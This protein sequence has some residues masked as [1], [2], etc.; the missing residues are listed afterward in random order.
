[1]TSLEMKMEEME[2]QKEKI[3]L[4]RDKVYKQSLEAIAPHMPIMISAA[5]KLAASNAD[6]LKEQASKAAEVMKHSSEVMDK[7]VSWNAAKPP[8]SQKPSASTFVAKNAPFL[9]PN[10]AAEIINHDQDLAPGKPTTPKATGPGLPRA[11]LAADRLRGSLGPCLLAQQQPNESQDISCSW[12]MM[13]T[14]IPQDAFIH[15]GCAQSGRTV[16]RASTYQLGNFLTPLGYREGLTREV[17]F[18]GSAVANGAAPSA[19]HAG[20]TQE[21]QQAQVA[22]LHR[23][24]PQATFMGNN[25]FPGVHT[26]PAAGPTQPDPLSQVAKLVRLHLRPL[27]EWQKLVTLRIV[28]LELDS[29]GLILKTATLLNTA[30]PQN[31]LTR[32]VVFLSPGPLC[33]LGQR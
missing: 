23:N 28:S 5:E 6:V 29:L 1:M 32:A 26:T 8:Q 12:P 7:A 17:G 19:R 10:D 21:Q 16:T 2:L 20:V 15:G 27:S 18:N 13:Y 24:T 31:S 33:H 3:A 9:V 25:L 22:A 14:T 30:S 4:E 11:I